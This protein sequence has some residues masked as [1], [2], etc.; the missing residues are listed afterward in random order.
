L[1]S[2]TLTLFMLRVFTNDSDNT[3]SLYHPAF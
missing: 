2:L 1:P 3:F